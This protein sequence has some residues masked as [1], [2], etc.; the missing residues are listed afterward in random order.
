MKGHDVAAREDSILE[1]IA[2]VR[3][4]LVERAVDVDRTGQFPH[5]NF[6]IVREAGLLVAAVDRELGG[7]GLGPQRAQPG[8]IVGFCELLLELA[9]CCGSTAQCVATHATAMTVVNLLGDEAQREFFGNET[10]NGS[11]FGA[12]A[13]EPG[14][15]RDRITGD[16]VGWTTEAVQEGDCYRLSGEKFFATNSTGADWFAV[17]CHRQ[18]RDGSRGLGWAY[19]RS[20]LEGVTV[21]D[22]WDA[23]G[24][25]GTA[26]GHVT[27]TDVVV[28]RDWMV[29]A[30][31]SLDREPV[32][33]LSWQ[34]MF[35]ALYTGIA[36]G[37]L[38]FATEYLCRAE[39]AQPGSV[40]EDSDRLGHLGDMVTL[41]RSSWQLVQAAAQVLQVD[42]ALLDVD[43]AWTAV[44]S[45]KIASTNVVLEVTSRIF[46]VC[47]ARAVGRDAG[48]D[49]YWR[50]ART[51]TL[52]DPVD[53]RR[54]MVGRRALQRPENRRF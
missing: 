39:D 37:A 3:P 53:Q 34:L 21:H 13:G 42:R 54:Q 38:D 28:P 24:Q 11:I 26:S 45:A 27:F 29:G 23:I 33:A 44:G 52:H 43:E 41:V 20:D 51:L 50:N 31:G 35:G 12:F 19:V 4:I 1:R 7:L 22:T 25:R 32:I 9:R 15:R 2:T 5:E 47:G 16:H 18:D 30:A 14:Q 48:G 40:S 36:R 6:E 17:L 8:D 10:L 46:Q 49:V